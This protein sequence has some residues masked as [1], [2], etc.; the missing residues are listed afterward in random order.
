[1]TADVT[2]DILADV[3]ADVPAEGIT[4]FQ[5]KRGF[6]Y[7]AEAFWLTGFA[8]E[9]G[10]PAAAADFGT[11]SGVMAMLLGRLGIPTDGYDV[12]TEW[13]PFWSQSIASS[14][15]LPV[16]LRRQ[17]VREVSG[18]YE[19][20]L[21]NPPY[22]PTGSGPA[23]PDPWKAAARTETTAT[24]AEFVASMT[25]CLAP[26]GRICLV[27]PVDRADELGAVYRRVDVGR[28]RALVELRPGMSTASTT[29]AHAKVDERDTRVTQWYAVARG[30]ARRPGTP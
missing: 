20:I 13:E 25:R 16:R 8:L 28:R 21:S 7:G 15:P 6:R 5:P 23:S 29:D 19:L 22:F 1:M 11:G 30:D 27:I 3:T 4:I 9:S 26:A 12:R 24:L 14:R 10:T 17:D 18:S 2:A